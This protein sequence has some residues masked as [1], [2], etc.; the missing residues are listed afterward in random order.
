MGINLRSV[1]IGAALQSF[2]LLPERFMESFC[3]AFGCKPYPVVDRL[4]NSSGGSGIDSLKLRNWEKQKKN[5]QFSYN[6][7][8]PVFELSIVITIHSYLSTVT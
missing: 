3:T 5:I 2:L 7:L 6:L 4:I 1:G 8:N